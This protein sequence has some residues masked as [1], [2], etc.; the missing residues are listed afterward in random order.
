[1][2][3]IGRDAFL[4]ALDDSALRIRVLDQRPST[5]DDALA[6]VSRTEAYAAP[7]TTT[8]GS[9]DSDRRKVRVVKADE[10][11]DNPRSDAAVEKRIRQLEN[12][13]A[14][15]RREVR[16]LN[17]DAE[18]WKQRAVAAEQAARH[19][20]PEYP[21]PQPAYVASSPEAGAYPMPYQSPSTY[22]QSYGFASGPPSENFPSYQ[23]ASPPTSFRGGNRGYRRGGPG[24]RPP[25]A[26]GR[27][28]CFRCG[29]YGHY[30]AFCPNREAA[31]PLPR[32]SHVS[33]DSAAAPYSETYINVKY[34]CASKT[35][36]SVFLVDSGCDRNILPARLARKIKLDTAD[37]QI[38]YAAN[39]SQIHVIGSVWLTL[40]I[41]GQRLTE[42]CLCTSDIDEPILG[43]TFLKK[44][45]CVW[46]FAH[47][48]LVIGGQ[49]TPLIK[50]SNSAQYAVFMY[51]KKCWSLQ[52]LVL[53]YQ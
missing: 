20:A 16:Q 50:R 41:G 4:T 29:A 17:A 12:D 15:Q 38:V 19:P 52:M 14:A 43:F 23:T 35:R 51:A 37:Q 32:N 1:M 49:P 30:Q 26:A 47:S 9:I 5:L 45:R 33:D 21:A 11:T 34:Q 8:D 53:M 46:H 3:I 48:T 39:G 22:Q 24:R 13:L 40:F 6:A 10:Q 42:K 31:V 7:A 18:Q 27:G 2:E 44:H 28:S 25:G 36:E